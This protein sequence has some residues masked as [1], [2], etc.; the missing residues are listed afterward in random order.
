MS[1]PITRGKR[2]TGT[3]ATLTVLVDEPI[4][5]GTSA[6]YTGGA[7]LRRYVLWFTFVSIAITAVWGGVGGVLLP[8]HVQLLE[9]GSWFTGADASVDLQQLSILRAEIAAGTTTATPDQQRLLDIASDF[10]AARAQSL[11]LV[12]SIGVLA[13]MLIQPIVGVLSDRTRSRLGRRVP[14]ILFGALAGAALLVAV[15]YAPSVAVLALL[16][17]LAQ[18]V[19][20]MAGAPV[21]TTLADRVAEEKRGTVSAMGGLGTFLGGLLG[22]IGAGVGFATLGLDLYFAFALGLVVAA[23]GFVLLVRDRSSLELVVP[24]HRWRAFFAGFTVAFRHAD[25]RW[26]WIARV[27]LTFG[28]AA[29]T[30]LALYM[31]QSYIQPALSATEATALFPLLTL[32]GLPG[33]LIAVLVAGRLSDRLGRRKPFVIFSSA[34]MAVSMLVPVLSPTLPALFVQGILAGIAFGAYL[35]VDQALFVDVLPD[36]ESAGRDLGIAGLGTNLGQALGPILAAQVLAIT[37]GYQGIWVAALVLVAAAAVVILP[38]K[39]A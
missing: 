6:H 36:A 2:A 19:I 31:M 33:T 16:W 20:N 15:R 12:T 18:V 28:Y 21:N 7:P 26:V 35:P 9:F 27:L 24:A 8:N 4:T 10:E 38:V 1:N 22:G 34:L 13:T 30:A 3:A 11:S 14:W 39:K 25:F 17:T 32:A 37:G 5:P 29:S 23:L